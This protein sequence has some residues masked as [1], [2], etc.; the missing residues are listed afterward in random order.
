MSES[1]NASGRLAV[2]AGLRTAGRRPTRGES[3]NSAE[4]SSMNSANLL[5]F[6]TDGDGAGLKVGPV[7]VLVMALSYMVIVVFLHIMTKFKT[8]MT[9]GGGQGEL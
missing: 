9:A 3:K 8:M 1:G 5:S 7:T 4:S 6:K 2:G